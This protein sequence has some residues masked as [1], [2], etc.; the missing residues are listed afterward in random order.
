MAQN[1]PT[2]SLGKSKLFTSSGAT[3]GDGDDK[4]SLGKNVLFHEFT[5][6]EEPAYALKYTNGS[7]GVLANMKET[8]GASGAEIVLKRTNG[9]AGIPIN[10]SGS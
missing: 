10:T 3:V 1:E 9:G 7:T 2:W 8:N 4:W 6:S 5:D